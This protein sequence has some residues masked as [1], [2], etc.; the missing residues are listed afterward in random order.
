VITGIELGTRALR[1]VAVDTPERGSVAAT[2]VHPIPDGVVVHGEVADATALT[3]A[4]AQ[5]RRD[6][7]LGKR[8]RLAVASPHTVVR[9]VSLPPMPAAEVLDAVQLQLHELVGH[10]AEESIVACQPVVRPGISSSDGQDV[11]VAVLPRSVAEPALAAA[12]AAKFEVVGFDLTPLALLRALPP[13]RAE[14]GG[15]VL[16]SV[17]TGVT[18]IAV[19]EAGVPRM[20]RTLGV[21]G[22]DLAAAD[23]MAFDRTPEDAELLL[24]RVAAEPDSEQGRTWAAR[25]EPVLER[26][27]NQLAAEVRASVQ[28]Y[29]RQ[30]GA[31]TIAGVLLT[32]E[33]GSTPG[34]AARLGEVLGVAVSTDPVTQAVEP[35]MAAAYGAARAGAPGPLAQL[36]LLPDGTEARRR[37]SGSSKVSSRKVLVGTAALAWA[38]S[39]V[40]LTV[41][42][43][44]SAAPAVAELAGDP[45]TETTIVTGPAGA[46][47]TPTSSEAPVRPGAGFDWSGFLA[48]LAASAPAE[49][50]FASLHVDA[51]AVT[52]AAL[53]TPVTVA[54][55]T[56]GPPPTVVADP[57]GGALDAVGSGDRSLTLVATATDF[58]VVADWLD[59]VR[60]LP[61]VTDLRL[62]PAQRELDGDVTFTLTATVDTG[63]AR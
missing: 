26:T 53:S 48:N 29:L 41:T 16:V 39:L 54:A 20:V 4:L 43:D 34:L 44:R 45:I 52:D 33:A 60:E 40:A 1:A 5:L 56:T 47:A 31:R 50:H 3:A 14:D 46:A 36:L 51:V 63:A 35:F 22:A 2:A 49:V 13:A 25:I 15:A 17:G 7:R 19:H 8:I 61:A 37:P 11:V 59:A 58:S 23:G 21:G 27:F 32:G 55:E 24:R 57:A 9:V 18:V 30:P 38:G 6:R 10:R 28:F 42:H 62:G 12:R